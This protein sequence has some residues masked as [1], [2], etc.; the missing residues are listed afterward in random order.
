VFGGSIAK[1]DRDGVP[2][3]LYSIPFETILDQISGEKWLK[4][5]LVQFVYV[6]AAV[7]FFS[8]VRGVET[9]PYVHW[10]SRAETGKRI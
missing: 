10:G 8:G 4:L 2:V 3:Y 5:L 1:D 6:L 7:K 9:K